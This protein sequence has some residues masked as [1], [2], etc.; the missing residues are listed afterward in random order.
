MRCH[1][2][3]I[4]NINMKLFNVLL[5][6][7]SFPLFFSVNF[8]SPQHVN[9]RENLIWL[10]CVCFFGLNLFLF[11]NVSILCCIVYFTVNS[12]IDIDKLKTH[13]ITTSL[14]LLPLTYIFM[15]FFFSF[16]M[17]HVTSLCI[18]SLI[19]NILQIVEQNLKLISFLSLFLIE[20][21]QSF[22]LT[23]N[24]LYFFLFD[25]FSCV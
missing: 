16:F 4:Q 3:D 19:N 15:T 14:Y 13:W 22:L 5:F 21:V 8:C 25:T 17:W 7:F 11:R 2:I 20:C 1:K 12:D 10:L 24:K 18:P 9:K 6:L 23:V